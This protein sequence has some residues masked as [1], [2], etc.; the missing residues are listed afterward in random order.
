MDTK[1]HINLIESIKSLSES[2]ELDELRMAKWPKDDPRAGQLVHTSKGMTDQEWKDAKI[3]I[4]NKEA[5]ARKEK[6]E[7]GKMS[8]INALLKQG[9]THE[10]IAQSMNVDVEDVKKVVKGRVKKTRPLTNPMQPA[11]ENKDMQN[12]NED[13]QRRH[14]KKQHASQDVGDD[15]H[16]VENRDLLK[17]IVKIVDDANTKKF[18]NRKNKSTVKVKT[19]SGTEDEVSRD[20]LEAAG[21]TYDKLTKNENLLTKHWKKIHASRVREKEEDKKKSG[22]ENT[23]SQRNAQ[24]VVDEGLVSAG[25]KGAKMCA[26]NSLC[27]KAAIAAGT[28]G[29]KKLKDKLKDKPEQLPEYTDTEMQPDYSHPSFQASFENARAKLERDRWL[30]TKNGKKASHLV[31]KQENE[32]VEVH[33]R[34]ELIERFKRVVLGE[35]EVTHDYREKW[36]ELNKQQ[37]EAKARR[38][39]R[40]EARQKARA[41]VSTE[42]KKK[43]QISYRDIEN[44]DPHLTLKKHM[45]I[46]RY[47]DWLEL[48]TSPQRAL[49]P[50]ERDRLRIHNNKVRHVMPSAIRVAASYDPEGTELNENERVAAPAARVAKKY[51]VKYAK[52]KR[53]KI[54]TADFDTAE[55][56]EEHLAKVGQDGYRGII[57]QGG[58]PLKDKLLKAKKRLKGI[59]S[60]RRRRSKSRMPGILPYT[61]AQWEAH[62]NKSQNPNMEH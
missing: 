43:S 30:A 39:K 54:Q 53:G 46:G 11:E 35:Q 40:Q 36:E 4:A 41:E 56:A 31:K 22:E 8:E 37:S 55:K 45:G 25:I 16:E 59:E 27:R 51:T 42:K 29:L 28:W 32:S 24:V 12:K 26:G 18:E 49:T 60:P 57:S 62:I 19:K 23:S 58:K 9:K 17:T 50:G 33:K 47:K 20:D 1:Q 10:Q 44:K 13:V 38:K 2:V 14:V 52:T 21:D 48:S 34:N 5:A 15:L 6:V 3:R 61:P 7:E